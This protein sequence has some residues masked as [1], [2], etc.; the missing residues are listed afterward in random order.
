MG[1]TI[2]IEDENGNVQKTMP[3]EFNLSSIDLLSQNSFKL[4][5]YIDPY[6]NTTFNAYM[7]EDLIED[8]VSLS[9]ILP[10]DRNRILEVIEYA[11]ECGSNVH[12]YLKFYGD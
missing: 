7:L 8:L 11:K 9:Q 5:K 1:W 3:E 6:G 12:T 4:L 10:V 2:T